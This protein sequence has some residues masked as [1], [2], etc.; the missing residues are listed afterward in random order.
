VTSNSP[1]SA[2][3]QIDGVFCDVSGRDLPGFVC[4]YT[5]YGWNTLMI[6]VSF[7]Y[8]STYFFPDL[9]LV[10]EMHERVKILQKKMSDETGLS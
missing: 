10:P 2:R 9:F 3:A 7:I 6:F 4:L 1:G 8:P 5:G